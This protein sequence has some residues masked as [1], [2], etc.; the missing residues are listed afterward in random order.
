LKKILRA[1]RYNA[2]D[3][4]LPLKPPRRYTPRKKVAVEH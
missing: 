3:A 4:E 2:F 1:Y